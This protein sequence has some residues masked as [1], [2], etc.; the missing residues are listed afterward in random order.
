VTR[1]ELFRR[2]SH[3]C[4]YCG[5]IF[6]ADAL[7][8]DHVQPRV[9]GGDQSAGNLVTACT[10]CNTAKGHMRVATYLATRPQARENFFRYAKHIWA[11]HRRTIED[12]LA[13]SDTPTARSPKA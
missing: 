10:V 5:E 7:T 1:D 11:R 2:D 8:I 3:R 4:V 6:E 12:E 9:R 13:T